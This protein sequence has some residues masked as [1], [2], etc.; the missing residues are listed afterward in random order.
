M[1]TPVRILF[2][3]L[4][5]ICRS[6][7][8]EGVFRKLVEERGL[9]EYFDIDS[10]G[11]GSWHIGESPDDRM[12]KTAREHGITLGHQ[13]ARRVTPADLDEYDHVLVMDNKNRRRMRQVDGHDTHEQK[14][15]L[16]RSFDPE[17]GDMEVPDPYFGG[18]DGFEHVYR[19]VE[20]TA[21]RLLDQLVEQHDIPVGT[22]K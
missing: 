18:E 13:T 5:N 7:L 16:F 11:N 19:I 17:P 4:G 3:C 9:S 21:E 22:T 10:A 20:R 15:Q 1:Q 14:I 8:A 12:Q 6:P 2:V